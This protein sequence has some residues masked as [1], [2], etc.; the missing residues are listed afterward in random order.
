MIGHMHPVNAALR[1]ALEIAA[2]VAM[3]YWG[4]G[5][6]EGWARWLWA[7]GLPLVAAALWGTF[8]VPGDPPDA[9]VAIPG[10]VRLLFELLF[11]GA[12]VWLLARAGRPAWALVL[13]VLLVGHYLA[14]YQR[15]GWLLQQR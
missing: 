12:A 8:R 6:H 14:S 15:L 11:F 2:L 13:G 4:W 5:Q 1:F 3:G 9:P 10:A 7:L